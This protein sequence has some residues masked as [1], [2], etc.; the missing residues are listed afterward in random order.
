M[1][2]KSPLDP[3]LEAYLTTKD[4]LKITQRVLAGD[5]EQLLART[6]FIGEP[7]DT[8]NALISKSRE[9]TAD[10]AIIALWAVFERHVIEFVREKL[11]PLKRT[12]P[13]ALPHRLYEKVHSGIERW[14]SADILDLLKGDIDANLLGL[15]KKIKKYRDWIAHR[16]PKSSAEKTDPISAHT[17][18]SQIM[19]LLEDLS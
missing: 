4:S 3:I 14:K 17:I 6:Q 8:S 19:N 2:P 5:M 9:Q 18:L 10:L 13:P 11:Q 7:L 1:S 12:P 15:A 16:N